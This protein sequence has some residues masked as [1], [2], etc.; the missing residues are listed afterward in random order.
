MKKNDKQALHQM[1]IDELKAKVTTLQGEYTLASMNN[2]ARKL[3]NTT[4]LRVMRKDVAILLTIIHE[5]EL[6]AQTQS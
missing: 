5:K 4:S 6:S 3:P 2:S 1:S